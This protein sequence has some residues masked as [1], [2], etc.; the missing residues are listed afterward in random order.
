MKILGRPLRF[1]DPKSANIVIF[2]ETNSHHVRKALSKNYSI[3]IFNRHPEDIWIGFRVVLYF[4]RFIG[5]FDFQGAVKHQSGLI[6]GILKQLRYIYFESCLVA[7]KPKAVVSF[8]DNDK[9]FHWLSKKCRRFPFIAIQNG[10]RPRPHCCDTN[11]YSDYYLQHLFCMGYH[12]IASFPKMGYHVENFYP[13]GSLL[14]SLYFNRQQLSV[15]EKYDILIVSTWRGNIGYQQDVKDT[16]RSMKIMDHLLARYIKDKDIKAAVILRTE[17]DSKDW[18][19]LEIGMSE[20]DYY[21]EIYGNCV[22]IIE[23]D[24]IKRNIY[25]L[26]QQSRVIISCLCSALLEAFAIG[27]KVLYCNFTGSDWY[28]QDLP[29]SIIT[30]DSNYESFAERLNELRK[31]SHEEYLQ[32]NQESQKYYISSFESKPTYQAISEKID[33]II[34]NNELKSV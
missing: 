30:S 10:F 18:S 3:A 13:V 16:M 20:E 8:I 27:K 26:M 22:D 12:A 6:I 29:P 17:R 31:M 7:M 11:D 14:A 4:F 2:N 32:V 28:Y 19:M 5:Q 9:N 24:F 33:K 1:G 34:E 25:P 15:N 23:T 21:R